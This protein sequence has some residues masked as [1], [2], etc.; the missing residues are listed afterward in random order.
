LALALLTEK[1]IDGALAAAEEAMDLLESLGGLEENESLVRL[2][3]AEALFASGQSPQEVIGV[4]GERLRARAARID[5][6]EMRRSFL[7]RVPENARTL[8]RAAEWSTLA[9]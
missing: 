1:K 9:S 5:V 2:A 6:V 3:R 4:A 8:A 7:E